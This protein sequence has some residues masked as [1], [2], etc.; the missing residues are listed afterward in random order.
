[1]SVYMVSKCSICEF[2]REILPGPVSILNGILASRIF[3]V[4]FKS[5]QADRLK[6]LHLPNIAP[7]GADFHLGMCSRRFRNVSGV[8]AAL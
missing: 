3:A 5:S 4:R 6:I 1:M 2:E 7:S 8:P